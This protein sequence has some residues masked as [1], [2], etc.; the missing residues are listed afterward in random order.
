[1]F[2][3]VQVRKPEL[4]I[5][6]YEIYQG[7]Y[8]GLCYVLRK[9]YGFLGQMTLTYDMTFLV[10]LFSSVY[11]VP[12]ERRRMRCM[13]HPGRKHLRLYNEFTEYAAHMNMVLTYYHWKD[14]REDEASKKAWLGM[15]LYRGKK[16]RAAGLFGRQEACMVSALQQLSELERRGERN[17]FLL[18]DCFGELMRGL[19]SYKE[20]VF[21]DY[22]AELGYHLGRFI[23]LMDALD[24][25]EEDEK[26]GC[27]NPL[28]YHREHRDPRDFMGWIADILLD[29]MAAAGAAY[30]KLPCVEYA[31]ILGN[32]LYAGVWNKFDAW[33]QKQ[34]ERA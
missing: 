33:T 17:I 30:Q 2:G 27:F 12:T 20:D 7:F 21:S 31:D 23:Y 11:Q 25:L 28:F 32:I 34:E 14:D 19:F 10:V 22:F 26:K 9:K 29:E 4:K 13:A 24:D 8:C 1:M 18:A 15:K 5:K 3:Y 6:D 16:N